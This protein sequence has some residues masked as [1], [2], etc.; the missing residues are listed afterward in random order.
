MRDE[1]KEIVERYRRRRNERDGRYSLFDPGNLFLVQQRDRL[2]SGMLR[3]YG[4]CDL[5]GTRI[6]E[7][8]CGDGW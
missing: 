2:L 7:V 6:L 3:A 4:L 1:A 5:S 8:G